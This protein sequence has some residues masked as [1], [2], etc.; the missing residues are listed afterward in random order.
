MKK[1]PKRPLNFIFIVLLQFIF[2]SYWTDQKNTLAVEFKNILFYYELLFEEQKTIDKTA[3]FPFQTVGVRHKYQFLESIASIGFFRQQTNGR[4]PV[5]LK[6]PHKDEID[7]NSA[8]FGYYNPE[9]VELVYHSLDT[10]LQDQTFKVGA[11]LLYNKHLKQL[12]RTYY[13]GYLFIHN[14]DKAVLKF[15][16]DLDS[17][18]LEYEQKMT[19]DMNFDSRPAMTYKFL[20]AMEGYDGSITNMVPGFW[21][22]R[23][24]DGTDDEFFNL[25][26]LVIDNF[27]K[28]FKVSL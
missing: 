4:V 14:R 19:N 16:M 18:K 6:G 15:N 25:L 10:L 7:Y 9:F 8:Q 27:D 22:R 28:E 24:V 11:Q 26:N 5:F 20:Y 2:F 3:T 13:H 1:I 21:I 17:L 23:F 12:A